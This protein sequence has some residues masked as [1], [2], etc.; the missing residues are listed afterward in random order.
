MDMI[1]R[2]L[3]A[4]IVIGGLLGVAFWVYR[5]AADTARL[6]VAIKAVPGRVSNLSVPLSAA[7]DANLKLPAQEGDLKSF[8]LPVN[9]F[10]LQTDGTVLTIGENGVVEVRVK[11]PGNDRQPGRMTWIPIIDVNA[12]P[13]LSRIHSWRCF[14]DNMPELSELVPECRFLNVAQRTGEFADHLARI[15]LAVT[16]MK[17]P[18]KE[19]NIE[20]PIE[21]GRST[22]PAIALTTEEVEKALRS[23]Q[24]LESALAEKRRSMA[25]PLPPTPLPQASGQAAR[26]PSTPSGSAA[27]QVFPLRSSTPV[28]ASNR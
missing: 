6:R 17:P 19:P 4:L 27:P 10:G 14:S 7:W 1:R 18:E 13:P 11:A 12:R 24:T 20:T 3:V 22:A 26:E 9:A 21:N 16:A 25:P 8:G 5:G 28:P 23:G 2:R 15:Q